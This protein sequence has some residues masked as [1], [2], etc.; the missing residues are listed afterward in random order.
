MENAIAYLRDLHNKFSIELENVKSTDHENLSRL[1]GLMNELDLA[2]KRLEL[3]ERWHI[4]PRSM[5]LALP[6]KRDQYNQYRIMED[7]DTDARQHWKEAEFSGHICRFNE[8]DLII[9]P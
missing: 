2:C 1:I 8:G 4:F 6:P 3:C 9:K 5:I 7:C